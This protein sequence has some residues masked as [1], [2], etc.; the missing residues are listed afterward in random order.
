MERDGMEGHL[1]IRV[2]EASRS[3]INVNRDTATY[4]ARE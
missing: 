2:G 1:C 4:V 3:L